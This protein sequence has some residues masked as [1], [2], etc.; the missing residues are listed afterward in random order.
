MNKSLSILFIIFF[1]MLLFQFGCSE[2]NQEP[3]LVIMATPSSGNAPLTVDFQADASDPENQTLTFQWNFGDDSSST[4]QN[5]SHTYIDAETFTATCTVTDS[6]SPKKS[7]SKTVSITVSA[8]PP[9]LSSVAPDWT[10]AHLPEF[11]LAVKG[12][13][14][15]PSSK[16][17]LNDLEKTVEFI[18]ATELR[19][20]I[21]PEDTNVFASAASSAFQP[22]IDAVNEY[23]GS[24]WVRNPSPGGDS[25]P[26]NFTI[27]SN[28]TFSSPVLLC[29]D[30]DGDYMLI[31]GRYLFL[32]YSRGTGNTKKIMVSKDDGK[33]WSGGFEVP[34]SQNDSA[35]NITADNRGVLYLVSFSDAGSDTNVML[36]SSSDQGATWTGDEL[37]SSG[38]PDG[39]SSSYTSENLDMKVLSDNSLHIVWTER[40]IE[41]GVSSN[42]YIRS[43]DHGET[44]SEREKTP[45]MG[46]ANVSNPKFLGKDGNFSTLH[47]IFFTDESENGPY[48]QFSK[49]KGLTWSIPVL[50]N[51]GRVFVD[52]IPQAGLN[53]YLYLSFIW[54][55]HGYW[56]IAS[57]V[58]SDHGQ[59]WYQ[60]KY[61]FSA[62]GG[63]LFES[64]SFLT[65]SADNLN[66]LWLEF[67]NIYWVLNCTRI[68]TLSNLD[69]MWTTV[70][71]AATG[72][73]FLPD[74]CA[75]DK[76]GNIYIICRDQWQSNLLYIV[77]SERYE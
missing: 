12:T 37:I 20:K 48:Y 8:L 17:V 9:T 41:S 35:F 1:L 74:S 27:R 39:A 19:C 51:P 29:T 15:I 25:Q 70:S 46:S 57:Q 49:D 13:N 69:S 21:S 22:S 7:V 47:Y 54:S 10:V 5:P 65:D 58:S 18:D 62:Y 73:K 67:K 34:H 14:F 6:G 50:I 11:T 4:D 23:A 52:R 63:N 72:Y 75:I 61:F 16:I 64:L 30:A 59:S 31:L 40:C 68:T 56:S 71:A 36:S 33:T 38:S 53:D 45:N 26:L 55:F 43:T 77:R 28:Y 44:W 76:K 2:K 42:Y 60:M 32:I 3:S 66:V 24:V